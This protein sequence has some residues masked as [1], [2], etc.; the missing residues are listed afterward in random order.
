MQ[1]HGVPCVGS[2]EQL[3]KIVDAQIS[4]TPDRTAILFLGDPVVDYGISAD[5]IGHFRRAG[6]A[7]LRPQPIAD[8]DDRE[9]GGRLRE[10]ALEEFLPRTPVS[11]DPAPIKNLVSGKRVVV[12]GAGG[13]IGSEIARQ[14]VGLGCTHLTLLDH[15]EF[16]LFEIDRELSQAKSPMARR[17]VLANVRDEA[18]IREIFEQERPD[19]VFH[20]AALKH[21]G[22]VQDNPAEGVLTNVQ[23]TWNVMRAAIAAGAGQFVLISTDKAVAPANVMGATKR[24]AENLLTLAPKSRTRLSTV[25]FGNVLGSAG[26]VVPIFRDQIARGGP[27]FVTHPEVSRYFMTIPEAV[28]LVLHS[29]AVKAARDDE[30]P[31]KFILEMGEPVKI[32]DLARQMIQLSGRTPGVDIEIQISG[33]KPGEKLTEILFD[34]DEEVGECMDGIMEVKSRGSG[35]INQVEIENLIA[36]ARANMPNK[37][38]GSVMEIVEKLRR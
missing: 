19:L 32:A 31:S 33:L 23:G 7:L 38:E 8:M 36:L 14:M 12:T 18:R 30:S 3:E 4:D 20:A 28:Q 37:V 15:S 25:R 5:R 13:S 10:I 1:L 21:V 35:Q 27:V 29:T 24:I 2:P 9:A 34:D 16:L 22:L 26:S 6:H 11:L 17:A